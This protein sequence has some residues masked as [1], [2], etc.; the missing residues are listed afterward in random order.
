MRWCPT[1]ATF[2]P[3]SSS[4]AHSAHATPWLIAVV[5]MSSPCK[6]EVATPTYDTAVRPPGKLDILCG[7]I[8]CIEQ[9]PCLGEHARQLITVGLKNYEFHDSKIQ[10]KTMY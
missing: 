1:K 8:I 4:N 2:R 7:Y 5:A 6:I 9:T 10:L 3:T